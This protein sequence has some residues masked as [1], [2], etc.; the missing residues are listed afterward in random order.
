M[1]LTLAVEHLIKQRC[2]GKGNIPFYI[3]HVFSAKECQ[4]ATGIVS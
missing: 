4:R 2:N 3:I 1:K